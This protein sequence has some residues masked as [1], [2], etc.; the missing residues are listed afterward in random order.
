MIDCEIELE[1]LCM[2]VSLEIKS[3]YYNINLYCFL[4]H[5]TSTT[6]SMNNS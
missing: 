4:L 3:D 1:Y 5:Y 2:E 6:T